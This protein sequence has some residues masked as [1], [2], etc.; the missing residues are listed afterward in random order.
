MAREALDHLRERLRAA[1]V[2]NGVDVP[3]P[4]PDRSAL[5]EI[6]LADG[7]EDEAWTE[8]N[9]G[10]C[11]PD[12]WL[13]LA[14]QREKTHPADALRVYQQQLGPTLARGGQHA[15]EESTAMLRR[16]QT[17]F[18]RL[19][20]DAEF[21]PYRAEVRAANRNKRAFLKLLDASAD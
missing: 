5:V 1:S 6:L 14:R 3:T 9:A 17:L 12:L 13:Q 20:R 21:G 16:I 8:A 19:G 18:R 15:Y 10:G 7:M 2:T 11:R 4:A